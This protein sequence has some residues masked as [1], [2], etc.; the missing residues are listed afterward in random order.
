MENLSVDTMIKKLKIKYI[1]RWWDTD[2][3]FP[4]LGKEISIQEKIVREKSMNKF[5]NDLFSHLKQ[6]PEKEDQRADWKNTLW[7]MI[8]TF[9]HHSGFTEE[10]INGDFAKSLP[11]IT[12][13]FIGNVKAFNNDIKLD[14][15]V[16]A[17]RNIWIMNILQ[18]LFNLKVEYTPSVFAYS[19]LYPYTD[20]YL[21]STE[22]SFQDKEYINRKFRLRLAGE[23]IESRNAYEKDLFDLVGIIEGQYPRAIF[24][25]LYESLLCIH[26]AQC[27]SLAQHNGMISP[28]ERDVLGISTEKGGASVLADAYLVNGNLS[29]SQADFAFAFGALLQFCDDLQDAKE[30]LNNGDMTMFS[31]TS[32]KWPLDNITNALF[33]FSNKVMDDSDVGFIDEE[34]NKMK[35]FLKK[36]LVLLIFEAISQNHNL[37]SKEYIKKIEKQLPF[38]MKY[39]KK[40][41]KKIRTNYSNF[42]SIHGYSIDDVIL[43]A[44]DVIEINSI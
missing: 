1:R 13:A 17:L 33:D 25:E 44:T 36:N 41:Y 32:E 4:V 38:R 18:V 29:G 10:E 27:K 26:D 39:T 37:Y 16:Q 35:I 30:D 5:L 22:I 7:S 6:C 28:Y 20:N 42:E 9:G 19:M 2:K 21:D 12:H 14:K 23:E 31:V 24:K 43:M 11:I 40:L 15:M 34:S 3:Y 8:K